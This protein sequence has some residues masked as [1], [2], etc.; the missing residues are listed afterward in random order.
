[1]YCCE[2]HETDTFVECG[3]ELRRVHI[4]VNN[5]Q[6]A[7]RLAM[8]ERERD[9]TKDALAQCQEWLQ[10]KTE[11]YAALLEDMRESDATRRALARSHR[12]YLARYEQST[13]ENR[14]LAQSYLELREAHKTLLDDLQNLQSRALQSMLSRLVRDEH[15]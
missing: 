6:L 9:A 14:R 13:E 3:D 10:D 8:T 7:Q 1:M 15:T 2:F 12:E 11:E 4:D 5:S